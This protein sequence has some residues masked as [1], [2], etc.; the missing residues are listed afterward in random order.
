MSNS[1]D[2]FECKKYFHYFRQ[3]D[4][5]IHTYTYTHT[6]M[7]TYIHTYTYKH[8]YIHSY[9][10]TCIQASVHAL[11]RARHDQETSGLATLLTPSIEPGDLVWAAG[12]V[13]PSALR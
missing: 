3:T 10:H 5:Y 1:V 13:K 7:P 8:T 12:Q 4:T 11:R 6:D 2:V 9:M